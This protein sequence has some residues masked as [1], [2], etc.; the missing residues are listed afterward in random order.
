MEQQPVAELYTAPTLVEV[1]EFT[2]DTRGP[3]PWG[4]WDGWAKD[5]NPGH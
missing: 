4:W 3:F 2:E 1:G 5:Y